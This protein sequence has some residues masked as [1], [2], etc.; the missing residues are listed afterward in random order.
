MDPAG[1]KFRRLVN[2]S[3]FAPLF[4]H[5]FAPCLLCHLFLEESA[6]EQVAY[7]AT[8]SRRVFSFQAFRVGGKV[9][10]E[11]FLCRVREC[12]ALR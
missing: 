6:K 5:L 11:G 12:G 2:P 1:G 8:R 3:L 4:A 10:K 7:L 9:T